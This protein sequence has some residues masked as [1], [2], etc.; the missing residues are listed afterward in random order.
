MIGGTNPPIISFY[1]KLNAVA[2]LVSCHASGLPV[3]VTV[4]CAF[5]PPTIHPVSLIVDVGIQ[6]DPD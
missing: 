1:G 4:H 5:S 3:A 6:L 2:Q